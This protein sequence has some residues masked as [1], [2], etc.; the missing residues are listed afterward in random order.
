MFNPMNLS[1]R[2]FVVTGASSGIG[3]DVAVFL[4]E[5]GATVVLTGRNEE[6]LQV[7][8]NM[9]T[10][11]EHQIEPFDL[12]NV[13]DI[14]KWFKYIVEKAGPLDGVVHSAGIEALRPL[15]VITKRSFNKLIDINVNS[16]I[17]LI[18]GFGQKKINCS[19]GSVVCISSVSGIV[20]QRAHIEYCGSKAAL[21]GVC[22][23]AAL[24]LSPQNIRVNC[25]A[26]GLVKTEL[27]KKALKTISPDQLKAIEDYHPF[28]IGTTR[29]VSN[30]VAFLL[31][32]TGRWITGTTLTVD[33]G[34]TAH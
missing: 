20:G 13:D 25:I 11:N 7:T 3:R 1:N 19:G 6:Q 15:K 31:A 18:K 16:A 5:L 32:D 12:T 9:M 8:F 26:P 34:Y 21:I 33:G 27:T 29:D 2:I 23:A 24:E 22:K 28:G 10:G 30:A 17:G 14:P 4:S